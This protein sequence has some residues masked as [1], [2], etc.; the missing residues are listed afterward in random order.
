M[1]SSLQLLL[2]PSYD[3]IVVVVVMLQLAIGLRRSY[4]RLPFTFPWVHNS[5]IWTFPARAFA[6]IFPYPLPGLHLRRLF[7]PSLVFDLSFACSHLKLCIHRLS[8][9][10]CPIIDRWNI[11]NS[12][13]PKRKGVQDD[14]YTYAHNIPN[15]TFPSQG[16]F[17]KSKCN[18]CLLLFLC[19]PFIIFY[20]NIGGDYIVV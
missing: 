17:A 15:A 2:N 1:I 7:I 14:N 4:V 19:K 12:S 20:R 10:S 16:G 8:T 11:F 6:F 3:R 5:T 9:V 13:W 18:A